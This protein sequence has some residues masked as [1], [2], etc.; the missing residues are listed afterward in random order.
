MRILIVT[1][2]ALATAVLGWTTYVVSRA[3]VEMISY[4]TDDAFYYLVPAYWFAHGQ[5][6][7]FDQVTQTSGFQLL[8][9][10]VAA[11]VAWFVGYSHA[12]PVLMALSSAFAVLTGLWVLLRRTGETYGAPIAATATA[13]T[14]ASPFAFRQITAG[15]EWGWAVMVTSLLV[16]AL[17]SS[18]RSLWVVAGTALL[19]TLARSDLVLFVAIFAVTVAASSWQER[20]GSLG[21]TLRLCAAAAAGAV[22]ALALTVVH[23]WLATGDWIPNSVAMKAFWSQTNPFLPAVSWQQ[24]VNS[25]GPGAVLNALRSTLGLRSFILIGLFFLGAALVCLTEWQQGPMRRAMAFASSAAVAVY[26]IA[27]ARGVNLNGDHYSSAIVVPIALLMCG[28]LA[29]AQRYWPVVAGA[30]GVGAAIVLATS[31]WSGSA[32]TRIVA[33]YAGDLVAA[34]PPGGRVAAWNAGIAGWRTGGHLINL[35]GLA[36]AGVV[37]PIKDGTLAC[38][39]HEN[40]VS[41]IMDWDFMFPG[42]IEHGFTSGDNEGFRRLAITRN[43]YDSAALFRCVTSNVT[44]QDDSFTLARYRLYAIDQRC[45]SILCNRERR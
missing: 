39:L 35:D 20:A 34:I 10:Y 13:L 22:F 29:A 32:S 2:A 26:T 8:Y 31:S 15:L 27:Y 44:P 5:G 9:G 16:A 38:Y 7:T 17:T 6:W 14:L 28:A 3:P 24:L 21:I 42:Q 41:Y 36:N 43:G 37:Q 40:D 45:L 19:V 4:M 30:V 12:L 33:R 11:M 1:F 23:S 18:K 25:T